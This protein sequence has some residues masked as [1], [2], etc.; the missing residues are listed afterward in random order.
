MQEAAD[1]VTSKY[2][3]LDFLLNNAGLAE[4]DPNATPTTVSPDTAAKIFAINTIAPI[5]IT[6]AFLPLMRKTLEAKRAEL[7]AAGGVE[8]KENPLVRIVFIS[9]SM[10]SIGA[11]SNAT[12]PAY[13]SSKAA[14][15]MY[16]RCFAF[17]VPE[18]PFLLLH[19]GW[20]ATDMG[21]RGNRSPPMDVTKSITAC[22]GVIARMSTD[23]SAKAI[24]A[25]DNTTWVW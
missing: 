21:S 19:P 20:V 5:E 22:L 18:I 14:L 23:R 3:R 17:E 2:G 9:S 7:K 4:P 25:F 16:V 10:G 15:N 24:E 12:A 11:V 8:K 13:R 6:K 1:Y